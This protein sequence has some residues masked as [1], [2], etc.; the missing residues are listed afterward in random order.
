M[1]SR[2]AGFADFF[3]DRPSA[4]KEK[5]KAAAAL[6][7]QTPS[8]SPPLSAHKSRNNSL[9]SLNHV[10]DSCLTSVTSTSTSTITATTT[11]STISN[12]H[13]H[14][15]ST[16]S[17]ATAVI[18]AIAIP[19]PTDDY[20]AGELSSSSAPASGGET[21]SLASNGSS[22]SGPPFH[23]THT[24]TPVTTTSSPPPRPS[25]PENSVKNEVTRTSLSASATNLP[26]K[27][28]VPTAIDSSTNSSRRPASSSGPKIY[29]K[30]MLPKRN[31]CIVFD[32]ELEGRGS[33]KKSEKAK[34]QYRFDGSGLPGLV[35]DPRLKIANYHLGATKGKRRL[36]KSPYELH[37]PTDEN[38]IGPGPPTQIAI[39]GLTP[40]HTQQDVHMHF[41]MYGEIA[42]LEIKL[43]PTTGAS[44]GVAMVRYREVN[45]RKASAHESA[46]RAVASGNKS[47]IG[48]S[49]VT[50]EFDRDGD[51]SRRLMEKYLAKKKK[52]ADDAA[53]EAKIRNLAP[54]APSSMLAAAK[55]ASPPPPPPAP[56]QQQQQQQ[57]QR[58]KS[59]R[60]DRS[61]SRS[62][63]PVRETKKTDSRSRSTS[64][65]GRSAS[66]TKPAEV[67]ERRISPKTRE[68]IGDNPYLF[69]SAKSIPADEKFVV[70]L[71]GRLRRYEWDRIVVDDSGFFIRFARFS[72]AERC[73]DMCDGMPL[74]SYVM[75]MEIH[76]GQNGRGESRS[77]SRPRQRPF[78]GDSYRPGRDDKPK[79]KEKE[80]RKKVVYHA[81]TSSMN[82]LGVD[83]RTMM[84]QDL[85]KRVSAPTIYD[86]ADAHR[87]KRQKPNDTAPAF[88]A[89]LPYSPMHHIAAQSP[90]LKEDQPAPTLASRL[91]SL[92]RFKKKERSAAAKSSASRGSPLKRRVTKVTDVRPLHHRLGRYESDD[93]D[94][95]DSNVPTRSA[96]RTAYLSSDE[97]DVSTQHA[98]TPKRQK[99]GP[100]SVSSRTMDMS[101]TSDEEEDEDLLR[102]ISRKRKEEREKKEK[103]EEDDA[104][105]VPDEMDVD[106]A[107]SEVVEAQPKGKHRLVISS[108]EDED[109]EDLDEVDLVPVPD[110][111]QARE[112]LALKSLQT[113]DLHIEDAKPQLAVDDEPLTETADEKTKVKKKKRPAKKLTLGKKKSTAK[114]SKKE[115]VEVVESED[116][117][118]EDA[119]EDEVVPA[120]ALVVRP[121][122]SWPE[123]ARPTQSEKPVRTFVDDEPYVLDLDGLQ[124]LVKDDEDL[125]FLQAALGN[126][127]LS[128]LGSVDLWAYRQK[129]MKF[130]NLDVRGPTEK[131]FQ[132]EG[133]HKDNTTG[134][135]RTQGSGRIP[136]AEKAQY[137]PHRLRLAKQKADREAA[138]KAKDMSLANK[139]SQPIVNT[140]VKDTS[141]SNRANNR[142]LAAEVNL[143]KQTLAAV[144]VHD[145]INFNQLKKR[146]KPVR[147]ARS[148]IH[149]WGLYAMENISNNE[150]IIEYV[151]EIV[152]QQVADLREKN[153]LRSG[154][155]SSYL[156]RIDET[157]VIDATKKGG[158]ARFINHSCTP[159]CTAKIIKVE[160]TKRIVIYALRDIHKDEELTYDYK[161]ERE[162]DSEERIPCL[163]GS[164]GCKGFLN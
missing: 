95:D 10:K 127:E 118:V 66:R 70:H 137:L 142:R 2:T 102:K 159:N 125:Q 51:R 134:S 98:G 32:P 74:F 93:S 67:I 94:E 111:P 83:L 63:T 96:S 84:I 12:H 8:T 54:K 3:P 124:G 162:I 120:V 73:F 155:G 116:E 65:K 50:V 48:M 18:Q 123:W 121:S 53:R 108:S 6:S 92:P 129:E 35:S 34:P 117:V 85:K 113:D 86:G 148:A 41:R 46:K 138:T 163:C 42:E 23:N 99:R 106:D 158:I 69:I 59:S 81:G 164:S 145:V 130:V 11:T 80:A 135:A 1:S 24:L 39:S 72:E 140:V 64:R 76:K 15:S 126:V 157:T 60:R 103:E 75:E 26:V 152:R 30:P 29:V 147:F 88:K 136:D 71:R 55:P 119:K 115:V 139:E 38:T 44:M 91:A 144:D 79:E 56:Q 17:T 22:S 109:E 9:S 112:D 122:D 62:R 104:H 19:T 40:L 90:S 146:K 128:D 151:G 156:F 16:S 89:P 28:P 61:T 107:M 78:D 97:D 133:Y 141:R 161:F 7:S 100:Q 4:L 27:S 110:I 25:S 14:S 31:Y 149:N 43:D 105:T 153:Y 101:A 49:I 58:D 68:Q 52:D 154:I 33:T 47:K 36:R 5:D 82:L 37:W 114:K 77:T 21:S 150:M 132:Y 87:S 160:G 143:Q 13:V 20:D 57:Q 131:R 45:G